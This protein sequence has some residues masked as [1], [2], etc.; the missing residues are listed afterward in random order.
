VN[1]RGLGLTF[2]VCAWINIIGIIV[3]SMF[4]KPT[5][6]GCSFLALPTYTYDVD[7]LK[8][9]LCFFQVHQCIT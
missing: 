7:V 1:Y 4:N 8:L 3:Q 6:F 2:E 9:R 5:M